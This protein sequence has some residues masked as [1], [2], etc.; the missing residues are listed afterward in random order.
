VETGVQRIFKYLKKLDSGFR[1][2]DGN[3]SFQAF[4]EAMNFRHF[5]AL[6]FTLGTY[7]GPLSQIITVYQALLDTL[8]RGYGLHAL[9]FRSYFGHCLFGQT[10]SG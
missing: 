9:C 10:G 7:I 8:S 1:R 4:Y 6:W 3:T 2:N 5:S